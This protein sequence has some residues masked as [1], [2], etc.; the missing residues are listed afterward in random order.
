MSK[1][2]VVGDIHGNIEVVKHALS[3]RTTDK[4]LF[5]GDY[6][7]SFNRSREDQVS[8]LRL[9]LDACED[10]PE[11]Y[12]G[13]IGNHEL[14]Y[15]ME[16]QMCSGYAYE[17]QNLMTHLKSRV[18][19]LLRSYVY[20]GDFLCTHAGVSLDLLSARGQTV[21]EYLDGQEWLQVGVGRG[22]DA[23]VGGLY[24]CDWNRE[25]V[26]VP[27]TPQIVGHTHYQYAEKEGFR[28]V[29]LC[30][31]TSYNVDCLPQLDRLSLEHGDEARVAIVDTALG[32]VVNENLFDL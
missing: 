23:P 30:N 32:T 25:F 15:I 7:D 11:R 5:M 10:M 9:V 24:W 13:L 17:T 16:G 28:T 2:L 21:K 27:G 3:Q 20:V 8:G 1:T 31:E 4:V 29:A 26:P 22:G 6:L 12:Q 19:R 14:S 18:H